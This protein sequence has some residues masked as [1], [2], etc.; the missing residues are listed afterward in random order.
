MCLYSLPEVS[1]FFFR[2]GQVFEIKIHKNGFC[3]FS[4]KFN[5]S[6]RAASLVEEWSPLRRWFT[7][8]RTRD[9]E[10]FSLV[11]YFV[12]FSRVTVDLSVKISSSRVFFPTPFP[13][14]VH[15][16]HI[17]FGAVVT[18]IV[19]KHSS[20]SIVFCVLD[21]GSDDIPPDSSLCKMI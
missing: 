13:K 16:F 17:F 6:R 1:N 15:D 12:Y 11:I 19:R 14:F 21:I 8:V 20:K 9:R 3:M 4:P 2:F 5:P 18:F 10:I 7:H